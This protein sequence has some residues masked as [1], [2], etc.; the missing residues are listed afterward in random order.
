MGRNMNAN[1]AKS[2]VINHKK[3][4]LYLTTGMVADTHTRSETHVYGGGGSG[5]GYTYQGTGWSASSP[6]VINSSVTRHQEL[7]LVDKGGKEHV[8]NMVDDL[9]TCRVGQVVTIMWVIKPGKEKGPLIASYNHNLGKLA[10]YDGNIKNFCYPSSLSR[11]VVL[12]L[13]ILGAFLIGPYSLIGFWLA[14]PGAFII[15]WRYTVI[16]QRMILKKFKQGAQWREVE[17]Y[18]KGVRANEFQPT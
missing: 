12:G 4:N 14:L 2:L 9:V 13:G 18:L 7:F 15:N 6:V 3:L 5:S 17:E 16:G 11:L 1:E 10:F 8:F